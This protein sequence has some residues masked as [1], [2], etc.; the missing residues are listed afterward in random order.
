MVQPDNIRQIAL[1]LPETTEAEH[2]GKPSFRVAGKIFCTL[3]QDHP[4]AMVKLDVEDQANLAAGYP[5][6]V[7]P[8]PGAWGRKGSTFIWYEKADAELV[9]T[10]MEMAWTRI[11]PSRLR[12][13][14]QR[15]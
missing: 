10:L 5:G 6:V 13:Q 12:S 11:A 2:H 15:T 1:A 8:V 4:R 7:E 9:R 14:A 3:H